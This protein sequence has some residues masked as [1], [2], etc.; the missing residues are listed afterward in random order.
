MDNAKRY[1]FSRR[2]PVGDDRQRPAHELRGDEGGDIAQADSGEC[3]R[4]A[5][6][7]R[8]RR[9]CKGRRSGEPIRRGD[10]AADREGRRP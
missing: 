6:G 8:N 7:E 9:V 2:A 4:E 10:I 3:R 5:T 1:G